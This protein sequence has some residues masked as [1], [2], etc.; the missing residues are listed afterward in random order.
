M[1]REAVAHPPEAVLT[2]RLMNRKQ[3]AQYMGRSLRKFDEIKHLFRTT[4]N[5][6]VRYDR[7]LM[8]RHIDLSHAA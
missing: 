3:A 8:D 7:V 2:P 5:G 4:D 1:K 6:L